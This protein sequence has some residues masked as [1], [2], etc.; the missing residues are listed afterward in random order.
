MSKFRMV[1]FYLT[2]VSAAGRNQGFIQGGSLRYAHHF[3][4]LGSRPV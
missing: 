3:G 4:A 1:R 2:V